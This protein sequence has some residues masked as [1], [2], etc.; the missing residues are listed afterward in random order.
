MGTG[1]I[2]FLRDADWFGRER[3]RGYA[4][5]VGLV[6]LAHVAYSWVQ[7][8]K[9]PGSDFLAFWGAARA[10][11]AGVPAKA[12][13]LAWQE[14]VQTAA[15]AG[16]YFAYVNPPPFLFVAAPFGLFDYAVAWIAW[17]AVTYAVWAWCSIKAFPRLWPLAAAFPGA[18]I[19]A[20]H[21]QNGFVTGALLVGGVYWLDRR[22]I[23]A[24]A[25]LGALIVKPHLAL[26]VP[27]WLAAGGRWRAFV[28]AGCSAAGLTLLSWL[29]FGTSTMLAYTES[30][31][32]SAMLVREAQPEFL[33]RMATPYAQVRLFAGPTVA[34]VLAALI[35][36]GMAILAMAS[37]RRLGRDAMA[38]GA[39][40]L[41][42]TA[43]ASPYLFNYDL[44]FL[45]LPVLWLALQGVRVGFRP[46]EKL[47]LLG[48]WIAPFATRA[49]ALPLGVNLMPIAAIVLLWMIWT[50]G[51][52]R[53]AAGD[54]SRVQEESAAA[55]TV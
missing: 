47:I 2:H 50:R 7:A 24:G 43:L 54:E 42:A 16:D 31:P 33:L 22:P 19:A 10:V 55:T 3:A 4:A 39:L 12:Y 48:L 28:A 52:A 29:A 23:L 6:S 21:A 45:V 15:V 26:L 36:V 30:W 34:A 5:I 14:G 1:P 13:D 40:M 49:I 9:P 8:Q 20:G 41:A 25:L 17:V 46:W 37:W 44:P 32:V 51:G 53:A 35:A 11:L 27:F 38:T 18:L